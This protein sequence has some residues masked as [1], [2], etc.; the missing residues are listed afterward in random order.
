MATQ[1]AANPS[2]ST[3]EQTESWKDCKATYRLLD[4]AEVSFT[5]LGSPHWKQ[6][7]RQESGHFLVIGDTTTIAFDKD[8][9]VDGLGITS[10][11]ESKGFMLHSALVVNAQSGEIVG[12]GGQTIYYRQPAPPGESFRDRLARDRESK[13][14]GEVIQIVGV[15][16]SGVQFT[17]V[18]DRGADNFEVYCHLLL[19]QSDWVVRAA[20]LKRL[21]S[22]GNGTV[23]LKDYLATLPVSGSYEISVAANKNQTKRTA[24][25][26]VRHGSLGISAPGD[27]SRFVR[28]CGIQFLAMRVVEVR[29]VDP[30]SGCEPVRWVL[31]T[32]HRV[33]SF[34]D[35]WRVVEYYEQ[36]PLVEEF[37][38]A[39]KTGCR[40]EQRQ[41]ET[42]DRWERLTAILSIVA[43]RL[44][45]MK[46]VAKQNPDLAAEKLVP[47]RWIKILT[48]VKTGSRKPIRTIQD[49]MRA[50]A[51]L[52]GHL[53]RKQDGE[54]GWITLW[55]GFN[56]L[57]LLLR[58]AAAE[59]RRCG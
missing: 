51:E 17:H 49:F 53:G 39:L 23:Q 59:R 57:T 36:R 29:E 20:Q 27:C 48:A 25:V 32:S 34:E 5:A 44:L 24:R 33:D 19:Q 55:R 12:L 31:Y 8:R 9:D 37:H 42:A 28:E 4:N 14:W 1:F 26:E 52:G 18:L 3:P 15:P 16:R 13:I 21:V 41:Y 54:P 7:M 40:L 2:G 30:P 22:D 50:L 46:T 58:G 38:K 47:R 10:T 43:V 45:Q 11:D 6:S 35:A 56:K